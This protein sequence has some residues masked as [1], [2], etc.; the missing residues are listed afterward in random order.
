MDCG[1][2]AAS[3]VSEFLNRKCRLIQHH[4][5]DGRISKLGGMD[6]K[7]FYSVKSE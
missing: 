2:E 1:E 6:C 5:Q 3:W 7:L 4:K